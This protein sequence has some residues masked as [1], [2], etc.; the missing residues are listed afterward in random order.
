MRCIA[1]YLPTGIDLRLMQRDE[2]R[3][4][5][6]LRDGPALQELADE[7]RFKVARLRMDLMGVRTVVS[8]R[9]A[10][11]YAKEINMRTF[12]LAAITLLCGA[13]VLS[14]QPVRDLDAL[15]LDDR[16]AKLRN[17]LEAIHGRW[18]QAFDHGDG[19]AM[20]AL[21]VDNL[22]LVMPDGSVWKKSGPRAG[23]QPK[24]DVVP[25]RSLNDVTVRQFGDTAILTGILRNKTATDTDNS[26][27]KSTCTD[28]GI[29]SLALISR[30]ASSN[31]G[32]TR[33]AVKGVREG[34]QRR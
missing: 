11:L 9:P 18:F 32:A 12:A 1:L 2:F 22:V 30:M 23:K 26:G 31:S 8:C 4:T 15:L 7:W 13:T 20:D 24:R 25:Q 3:R 5:Q 19:A 6:L 17:E 21:E 33:K 27:A 14:Q 29:P 10:S 16:S 34:G 28:I